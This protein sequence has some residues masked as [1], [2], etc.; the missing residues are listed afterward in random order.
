MIFNLVL[1]VFMRTIGFYAGKIVF[2][3]SIP[4][5]IASFGFSSL[6]I[7]CLMVDF[8]WESNE[9]DFFIFGCFLIVVVIALVCSNSFID[10]FRQKH[11][12]SI[13]FTFYYLWL[14]CYCFPLGITLVNAGVFYTFSHYFG[15]FLA[16]GL[17]G[18]GTYLH[19][20]ISTVPQYDEE[21]DKLIEI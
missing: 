17:I 4:A 15:L 5:Q 10:Y 16:L 9:F 20:Y 11:S 12:E 6:K 14:L 18:Y 7:L 2:E 8:Y 3:L 13:V 1:N 19:S 21:E